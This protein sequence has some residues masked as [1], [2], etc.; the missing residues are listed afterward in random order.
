MD[1]IKMEPEV[2]PLGLQPHDNTHETEENKA[3]SEERNLLNLQVGGTKTECTDHSC[4]LTSDINVPFSFSLVKTE[5]EDSPMP[6]NS[7]VLK[8]EVDEGNMSHL[9]MTGMKTEYLGQSY[10]I[11]TEIKVEDTPVRI[12]FP[13]VKSGIDHSE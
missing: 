3:L 2:D 5:V 6:I 12:S 11:K 4:D 1:M 8:S 13:V 10:D 9:E 7:P